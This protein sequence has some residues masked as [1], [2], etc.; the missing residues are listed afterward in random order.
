MFLSIY[1]IMLDVFL[2]TLWHY[3]YRTLEYSTMM[4]FH[5]EY[6]HSGHI[7]L[8]YDLHGFSRSHRYLLQL[9]CNCSPLVKDTDYIGIFIVFVDS[10][11]SLLLLKDSE[12]FRIFYCYYY[13]G[14]ILIIILSPGLRLASISSVTTIDII[15]KLQYNIA[16]TSG[17]IFFNFPLWLW[18]RLR[19]YDQ[20]RKY[21]F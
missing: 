10:V 5:W 11:L 16:L 14:T 15:T 13:F 21:T 2:R 4:P 18:L 19:S 20:I 6:D 17:K 9:A 3:D 1:M 7:G 12:F 8:S